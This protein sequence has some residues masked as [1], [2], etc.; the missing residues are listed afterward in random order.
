MKSKKTMLI[1]PVAVVALCAV[2]LIGAGF[3]A[4]L[5]TGTTTNDK[6]NV[7]STYI[8]LKLGDDPESYTGSFNEEIFYDT[9]NDGNNITYTPRGSIPVQINQNDVKVVDLGS[10]TVTINNTDEDAF[11]LTIS[12]NGNIRDQR[13]DQAVHFVKGGFGKIQ[14]P[15]PFYIIK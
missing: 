10:V 13:K 14:I 15:T 9:K 1:L 2:A 11:E 12:D 7:D 5:Y 8:T 6:N 4:T 3:A